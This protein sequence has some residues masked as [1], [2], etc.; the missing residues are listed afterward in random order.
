MKLKDKTV[1]ITGASS[2]IGE[3][4]CYELAKYNCNLILSARRETELQRVKKQCNLPNEKVSIL[5]FD[6]L[7]IPNP[8]KLAEQA[9]SFYGKV[10][11]LVNSG[12]ISQ[13]S[14][15]KDTTLEIDRKIME[16][17]YFSSIALTKAILPHM[18][19]NKEGFVVAVSSISGK[20]GFPLRSAYSASKH[21]L[22]GFFETIQSEFKDENINFMIAVPGR[23]KTNV[24]INSITASGASYGKMD[25][26]QN[27]GISAEL[28]GKKLIKAI[29]KN[30][31]E[32]NIGGSEILM[33][34]IHRFMPWLY[35]F[36]TSR[37]SNT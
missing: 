35:R 24:S 17:N 29:E 36:I 13:R 26:G 14:L 1:W 34:Y 7:D 12:G 3:Y 4:L 6:L 30:R 18:I 2:G 33:V 5:P 32:V 25:D 9:I 23:V 19:S 22:H 21:A 28:C 27:S 11:L 15:T 8:E 31:K 16:V 37:I 10:D 20:F